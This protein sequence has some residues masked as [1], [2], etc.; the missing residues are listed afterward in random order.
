[1]VRYNTQ[2]GTVNYV[3]NHL[4]SEI[5]LATGSANN[6]N[7][8]LVN[9]QLNAFSFA[10]AWNVDTFVPKVDVTVVHGATA[11]NPTVFEIHAYDQA[12]MEPRCY[13][14]VYA[15]RLYVDDVLVDQLQF[16]GMRAK[17]GSY[18]PSASEYYY[19]TTGACTP[20]ES[21]FN[22]PSVLQYKLSWN[23]QAGDHIWR[24]DVLDAK[25]NVLHGDPKN[26]LPGHDM[27]TVSLSGTIEDGK[28]HL[29]WSISAS[30]LQQAGIESFSVWQDDGGTDEY[31][32][33]NADPILATAGGEDYQFT[34]IA[35]TTPD[36]LSY[37]LT[38]KN[39]VG[40]TLVLGQTRLAG[41]KLVDALVGYPNPVADRYTVTL[42]LAHGGAT[43]VTIFDLNGRRV[44]TLHVGP[45]A[46]GTTTLLWDGRD[47]HGHALLNGMYLL[48]VRTQHGPNFSAR[49]IAL[50]R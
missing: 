4:H 26:G 22:S 37:R 30:D 27:P 12:D 10:Q 40:S 21:G 33:L 13:N 28:V 9:P 6:G 31:K 20:P 15:I 50:F 35:P 41:P 7:Q 3:K 45:L 23:T 44:R 18:P 42:S 24:I 17:N 8:F 2:L 19:C 14:G 38:A 48:R 32:K 16:D 49:K 39:S 11:G 5:F 1:V 36:T 29:T 47:D 25:G 43:E 46:P 34:G